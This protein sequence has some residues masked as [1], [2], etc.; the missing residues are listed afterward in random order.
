M[1]IG[2]GK[3]PKHLRNMCVVLVEAQEKNNLFV[4]PNTNIDN[5]I[6]KVSKMDLLVYKTRLTYS[7]RFLRYVLD[8]GLA[9]RGHHESEESSN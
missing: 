3:D 9:F 7:F 5:G 2:I 6:V 1:V 4:A 8:Q